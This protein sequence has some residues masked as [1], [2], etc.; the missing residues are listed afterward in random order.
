LLLFCKFF[1]IVQY[2]LKG[3]VT[4]WRVMDNATVP[5]LYCI[6]LCDKFIALNDK[7]QK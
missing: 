1:K 7:V 2:A 6:A 5:F 4:I 3:K